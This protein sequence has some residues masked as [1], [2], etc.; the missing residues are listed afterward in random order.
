VLETFGETTVDYFVLS[1][2]LDEVEKVRIRKGRVMAER[3]RVITPRYLVNNALENFGDE[4]RQYVEQVLSTT[5]GVR[6][7]EYGLRFRKEEYSEEVVGGVIDDV[8]DQVSR[9]AQDRVG[10]VCGVII[11]VDDLWEVSLLHFISSLVKRS[12]PRNA[13]EMAGRGLLDA[14]SGGNIPNAVRIEIES[15]FRQAAGSRSRLEELGRKLREYG[16]FE[17]YEDRFFELYRRAR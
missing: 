3:P 5:E 7:I 10:D 14:A 4:A 17:E 15:D 13:K 8:A 9:E 16:L 12:L 1:E 11:G 2:V 6:I